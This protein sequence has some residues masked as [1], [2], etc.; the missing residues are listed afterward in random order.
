MAS[1]FSHII[2]N[3]GQQIISAVLILLIT[4][5]L[6]SIAYTWGL[7]M[8]R[9][10]QDAAKVDRLANYFGKDYENSL[11]RKIVS[12]ANTGGEET[13]V[14]DADGWWILHDY[15]ETGPQNNSIEFSTFSRQTNVGVGSGWIS[16]SGD[17]CPP[18]YGLLGVNE[19]WAVCARADA[20]GEGYII[21]YSIWFRELEESTERGYKI[22]LI[23]HESGPLSSTGKRVRIFRNRIYTCAAGTEPDCDKTLIIT[24]IK[25]LLE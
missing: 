16:L 8:I 15:S 7:P 1:F 18:E 12:V 2:R 9:K 23:R 17:S 6:V 24:E 5:A 3:K 21:K 14:I 25:I 19:P 13:F 10:R 22:R 20:T 4:I 11:M